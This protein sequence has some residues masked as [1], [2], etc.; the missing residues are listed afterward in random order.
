[1]QWQHNQ[2]NVQAV[3]NEFLSFALRIPTKPDFHVISAPT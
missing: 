3:L 1:M 2:F